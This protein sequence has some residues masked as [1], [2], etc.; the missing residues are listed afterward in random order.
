M[1][2]SLLLLALFFFLSANMVA[3][4]LENFGEGIE[5]NVVETQN[6]TSLTETTCEVFSETESVFIETQVSET[7]AIFEDTT[8]PAPETR[9]P[10]ELLNSPILKF[11]SEMKAVKIY[12]E[13][14]NSGYVVISG[15]SQR[16]I[17]GEDLIDDFLNRTQNG[18]RASL[19]IAKYSEKYGSKESPNIILHEIA[20]DGEFYFGM[21]MPYF[22]NP[23]DAPYVLEYELWRRGY[24][25]FVGLDYNIGDS[26]YKTYVAA[27][28]PSITYSYIESVLWGPNYL[29][30]RDSFVGIVSYKISE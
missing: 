9:I 22:D 11:S 8:L 15:D 17:S 25:Y 16:I 23:E 7:S 14:L 13:V 29:E 28:D 20:Y 27:D 30:G 6:D 5:P 12:A 4:T 19:R 18:E 24:K 2:R 26:L 1:K 3:C 21:T 10:E